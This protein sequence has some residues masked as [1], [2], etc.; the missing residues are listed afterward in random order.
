M[1]RPLVVLDVDDTLYLER[2]YVRSGFVAVGDY[3]KKT[4]GVEGVFELAWGAFLRGQRGHIFDSIVEA[5]ARLGAQEITG[6]LVRVY[7]THRPEIALLPDAERFLQRH[8]SV[9][10]IAVVTDGPAESQ[11]RKV[12]ALGLSR[13]V[14]EVVIT[15]ERGPGWAKPAVRSFEYLQNL[16]DSEPRDCVYFGD[17]PTKDFAGP[18]YL[19]WHTV[20][21]RRPG[22]LHFHAESHNDGDR[23]VNSFADDSINGATFNGSC[24][25][26]VSPSELNRKPHPTSVPT[27][28]W[29]GL[30]HPNPKQPR[31]LDEDSLSS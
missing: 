16:F 30:P 21:V 15:S 26:G 28:Y 29:S 24:C 31:S 13:W 10:H 20:R 3:V 27:E 1:S 2:D 11:R 14:T 25:A 9:S 5:D 12:D 6:D 19:G 22:G 7:R 8:S 18:K 23:V 4:Y 17:N